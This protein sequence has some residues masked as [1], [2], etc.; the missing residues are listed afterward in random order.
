MGAIRFAGIYPAVPTA[1]TAQGDLDLGAQAAIVD[2]LLSCRVHGIFGIGSQGESFA[3]S[4]EERS[5]LTRAYVQAVRGRVPVMIGTGAVTTADTVALSR[6]AE[7]NGADALSVITPYFVKLTQGEIA[8]HY[9]AVLRAVRIPV[10]A[11]TNP[12][13]T[14]N[15]VAPETAAALAREFAHFVGIKDSTGDLSQVLTYTTVCP[16]GFA[17]FVGRDT[18]IFSALV[19]ALPGAVAATASAAPELAVGIYDAVR[20]G[21][22]EA[23]RAL[24][25]RLAMLRDAFDLGSFPVVVKEAMEIRGLP[26]GPARP[27][28]SPLSPSQRETLRALLAEVGMGTATTDLSAPARRT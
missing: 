3:L 16:Q 22:L 21:D 27:P 28:V 8:A 6:D 12:A 5:R 9:R 10:L 17:V 24:Q 18:L 19:N 15:N 26:A 13:R 25:A 14:G 20:G 11:Y 4:F 23:G 1:F 2:W 7:A